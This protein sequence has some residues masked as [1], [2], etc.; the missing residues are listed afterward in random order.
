MPSLNPPILYR[1]VVSKRVSKQQEVLNT[2][3][4]DN[5]LTAAIPQPTNSTI[6]SLLL[7]DNPLRPVSSVPRQ[8]LV[9]LI[10]RLNPLL[11]L[12][13]LDLDG[14]DR[15]SQIRLGDMVFRGYETG[16]GD[17]GG[18]NGVTTIDLDSGFLG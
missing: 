18:R 8:P 4:K 6:Q 17:V 16:N 14:G 2:L 15:S 7:T 3:T 1:S 10:Q 12:A 9:D 5:G 11:H 13:L